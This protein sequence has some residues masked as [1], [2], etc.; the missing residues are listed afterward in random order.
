MPD[1]TENVLKIFVPEDLE[2]L[3][4]GVIKALQSKCDPQDENHVWLDFQRLLPIPSELEIQP[5]HESEISSLM[6]GAWPRTISPEPE[7]KSFVEAYRK[8][9]PER[10][11]SWDQAVRNKEKYGVYRDYE[12]RIAR[13]G[14]RCLP[15]GREPQITQYEGLG[16]YDVPEDTYIITWRFSTVNGSCNG[17]VEAVGRA[18]RSLGLGLRYWHSDNNGSQWNPVEDQYETL[19]TEESD[20]MVEMGNIPY[21]QA[22]IFLNGNEFPVDDIVKESVKDNPMIKI[23]QIME[24][25]VAK[26]DKE[27][28][29]L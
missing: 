25:A 21:T 2:I 3:V 27:S 18:C 14:T 26:I 12:W 10:A 1:Y 29:D 28:H 4:E 5:D 24:E 11:K 8:L 13:W 20:L 23:F 17:Y 22:M 9:D 7:T 15:E 16:E 6:R 19:W